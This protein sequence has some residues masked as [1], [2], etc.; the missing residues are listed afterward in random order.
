M[1]QRATK[2]SKKVEVQAPAFASLT[3]A[4]IVR[5]PVIQRTIPLDFV[6]LVAPHKKRRGRLSLRVEFVPQRARRSGGRNNGDGTW[7]LASDELEGLAYL[8][9]DNLAERTLLLRIMALEDA[10]ATTLKIHHLPVSLEPL[11][12]EPE[13][14]EKATARGADGDNPIL[15]NQLEKMHSL[16]AV[17]E[18]ELTE[19]RAALEQ[20]TAEKDIELAKARA[21]WEQQLQQRL[22]DAIIQAKAEW[23]SEQKT[24]KSTGDKGAAQA[25]ARAEQKIAQQL[26]LWQA[27]TE[28]RLAAERARWKGERA[29]ELSEAIAQERARGQVEAGQRVEAERARW[30]TE[31]AGDLSGAIAQ[32]R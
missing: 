22:T 17:R 5:A 12:A 10:G 19:L 2:F 30:K 15:H 18:S 20:A 24:R 13:E 1:Q 28:E 14:E 4:D 3:A 31:S 16:F 8:V 32:E 23:Q 26:A 11:V 27:Q 29:G 6:A 21:G 25:D 9:P 7:S